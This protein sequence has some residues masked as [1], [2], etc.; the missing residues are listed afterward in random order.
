MT[1]EIIPIAV[2]TIFPINNGTAVFL[3]NEKKIFVIYVEHHLGE[4]ISMYLEGRE[5]ERPLTHDLLGYLLASFGAKVEYAIITNCE[6][7]IFFSRLRI[8]ASNELMEK[9]VVDLDSRPSDAIA[10]AYQQGAPIFV[11]GELFAK[12]EDMSS[13]LKNLEEGK[14]S[15]E[16]KEEGESEVSDEID[17]DDLEDSDLED[18]EDPPSN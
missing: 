14:P 9:K 5:K 4:A 6:K 2:K 13:V 16:Q 12:V 10:I 8:T 3:G 18:D 11:T 15:G 17:D 1:E 7:G